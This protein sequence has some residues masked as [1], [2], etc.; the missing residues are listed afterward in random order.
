MRLRCYLAHG[1]CEIELALTMGCEILLL[2]NGGT[3][4]KT[5]IGKFMNIQALMCDATMNG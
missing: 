3:E 2:T 5:S 4:L 1:V